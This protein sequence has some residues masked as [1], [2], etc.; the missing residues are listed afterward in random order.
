MLGEGKLPPLPPSKRELEEKA[1]IANAEK[2][3]LE[4]RAKAARADAPPLVST[5]SAPIVPMR[6]PPAVER[7]AAPKMPA[8][9]SIPPRMPSR[10]M[11]RNN[12]QTPEAVPPPQLARRLPPVAARKSILDMGFGNKPTEPRPATQAQNTE[13]PFSAP[14]PAPTK[15]RPSSVVQE[16]SARDFNSSIE[17]K[18]ALV[19]FYAPYCK[20][21][22]ELD[23]ILKKLAE[24]FSFASDKLIIAK[25]DV[26]KHK[27]F[28]DTYDIK[29]Y[30]TIMLF[31]PG[32]PTPEKYQYSRKLGAMTDFIEE[33]TGINVADAAMAKPSGVPPPINMSSKPSANE[34]RAVQSRPAPTAPSP[35]GCLRCRD[36]SAPD[37]VAA[38]Y[39]RESLPKSYDLTRYL[40]DVLCTPFTSATDK[41]RAIFTWLHHNVAYDV[42]AFFGNRVKHVEPRDTIT[43]GLAVCGGYAGLYAA[44]ALKA[45]LEAVMVTGHGKGYGHSALKPGE[46]APPRNPSGHAW[47]AVRIDGGEWKLLDPCWGAGNLKDNSYYNKDFTPSQFTMSNENFGLKH[48]PQDDKYFF[49]KDGS[50]PTWEEYIIGPCA[51]E[52]VQVYGDAERNNGI[53]VYSILPLPKRISTRGNPNDVIRFQFSKICEHWNHEVNGLGKPYVIILK[54]GG[55]DGRK[56]D[57][58]PFETNG[59]WWWLDVERKDLGA[60]GQALPLYSVVTID[61][62]DARGMTNKEY[63]KKKGRCGYS[64]GGVACWDLV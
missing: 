3:D 51:E 63:L 64:F 60:A 35:S 13:S 56:E 10:P 61:G 58:V 43:T 50:I 19:D 26:D 30:P 54:I 40:A 28:M 22:V 20:Y 5:R 24:A 31:E 8:R 25:V 41:A 2:K 37:A 47:N 29:G 7:D 14:R 39:P 38:K 15:A 62:K 18:Y 55:V 27:S 12:I 52:T 11:I 6:P 48:F 44:I 4:D 57:F 17:G 59:F 9:P 16:L 33:K 21:C 1:R 34:V 53:D 32:N 42:D 49:R 36:F 46:S 45:G 23:P